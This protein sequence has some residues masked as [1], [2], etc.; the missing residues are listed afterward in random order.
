MASAR[1]RPLLISVLRTPMNRGVLTLPLEKPVTGVKAEA[2]WIPVNAPVIT[3]AGGLPGFTERS[4]AKQ[5]PGVKAEPCSQSQNPTNPNSDHKCN[6]VEQ[7][8]ASAR[9]RPLFISVLRTSMNR[10]VL[11]LPLEKTVK[12]VKAE[13]CW[14]PVSAPVIT[15]AG[16]LPG[17]AERSGAKQG[18][19]V[20]AEPLLTIPKSYKSQFRP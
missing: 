20:K 14:L 8:M 13:A 1:P 6:S 9:P 15:A 5:G 19:G 10:G 7:S 17:F 16:G 18:P 3:A 12:G 4:G 2:G 11:T